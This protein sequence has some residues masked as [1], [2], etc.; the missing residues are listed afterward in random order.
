[1]RECLQ[2]ERDIERRCAYAILRDPPTS[3]NLWIRG[4]K[5]KPGV[6]GDSRPPPTPTVF[7]FK[8]PQGGGKKSDAQEEISAPPTP[9]GRKVGE[10][11]GDENSDG[12]EESIGPNNESF[13]TQ[14]EELL[15][16]GDGGLGPAQPDP[17]QVASSSNQP[18]LGRVEPVQVP[19]PYQN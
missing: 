11:E 12:L 13:D 9:P 19:A 10:G 14:N 1:M 6:K 2:E 16:E 17:S 5:K 15:A 8:E 3:R 18:E 7:Q 4:I